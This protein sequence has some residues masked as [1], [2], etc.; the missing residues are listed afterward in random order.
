MLGLLV[1]AAIIG[2]VI[3]VMEEDEFPGWGAMIGTSLFI[4][5]A[6]FAAEVAVGG[7]I[8]GIIAGCLASGAAGGVIISWL[9]G[10]SFRRA[11]IATSIYLTINFVLGLAFHFMSQPGRIRSDDDEASLRPRAAQVVHLAQG[12]ARSG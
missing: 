3:A 12:E 8:P 9:C 4:S 2:L 1:N 10:M 5:L 6:G 11:A 7:G